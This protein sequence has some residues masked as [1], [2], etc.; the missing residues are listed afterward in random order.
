M[1]N[2]EQITCDA[3]Y[4][5]TADLSDAMTDSLI[6]DISE[7][8]KHD[9]WINKSVGEYS[10]DQFSRGSKYRD[11]KRI[12]MVIN[13]CI[14]KL[15]GVELVEEYLIKITDEDRLLWIDEALR[16]SGGADYHY[17][18]IKEWD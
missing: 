11:N 1:I 10:K 15:I 8:K 3:L 9:K 18:Y 5:I 17:M 7:R 16:Y 12:V 13:G 6:S 4:F 2:K 14:S